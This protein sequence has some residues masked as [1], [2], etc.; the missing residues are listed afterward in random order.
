M[1]Y[2]KNLNRY[3]YKF[4]KNNNI[5]S[6]NIR[7]IHITKKFFNNNNNESSFHP[8]QSAAYSE[9]LNEKNDNNNHNNTSSKFYL[10]KDDEQAF[11]RSSGYN[12]DAIRHVQ[13]IPEISYI[14]GD[15]KDC[16]MAYIDSK[17]NKN[18][19][20]NEIYKHYDNAYKRLGLLSDYL[21]YY[22]L[23]DFIILRNI[24]LSR[25]VYLS[26][27]NKVIDQFDFWYNIRQA[28]ILQN[29]K[30]QSKSKT[31]TETFETEKMKQKN[32]MNI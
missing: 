4:Y 1:F 2:L 7:Y 10:N 28:Q 16:I 26:E 23:R 9:S 27:Y 18:S 21:K 11:F 32:Y 3:F 24:T 6:K 12:D 19:D 29:P 8:Y 17:K 31:E 14:L 15:Y 30:N 20:T 22:S 25:Y 5:I 13:N